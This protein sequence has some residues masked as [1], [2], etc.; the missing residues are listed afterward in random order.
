MDATKW[1]NK[2]LLMLPTYP[3]FFAECHLSIGHIS[4]LADHAR[5]IV[6]TVITGHWKC[7]TVY[8]INGVIW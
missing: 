4:T 6:A 2:V 1:E 5:G 8:F 3:A 7:H